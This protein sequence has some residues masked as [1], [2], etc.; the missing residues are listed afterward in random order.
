ML[1]HL[2]PRT[3]EEEEAQLLA[4]IAASLHVDQDRNETENERY[5]SGSEAPVSNEVR[6]QVKNSC[7]H[8]FAGNRFRP[9][10]NFYPQKRLVHA[11][12]ELC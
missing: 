3:H 11:K 6:Q 1:F 5:C 2:S 9:F 12:G 8:D 7:R 10:D 4:A